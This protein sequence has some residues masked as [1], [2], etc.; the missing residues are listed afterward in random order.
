MHLFTGEV[1]NL[2]PP[3]GDEQSKETG[4]EGTPYMKI[5][6]AIRLINSFRPFRVAMADYHEEQLKILESFLSKS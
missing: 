2:Q 3:T 6:E 4:W 1:K 5:Q